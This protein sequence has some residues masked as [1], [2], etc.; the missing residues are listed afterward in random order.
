MRATVVG[1]GIGGLAA[2]IALARDGW[3]VE[4]LEKEPAFGELGAG[5]SLWANA[6]R[7]LDALGA[8]ERVRAQALPAS[9]AGIRDARGRW[10]SRTDVAELV[11]RFGATVTIRRS[12]L[13]ATLLDALP[14]GV[15]RP[16][17]EV[18]DV[19]ADGTVT[20]SA[21][22]STSDLVVGADG[23]HSVVRHALWPEAA[24]PRYVGYTAWR[25]LTT[26]TGEQLSGSESLGRGTRFGI[27]PLRGDGVYCFAAAPAPAGARSADGEPAELRRQFGGWHDPIPQLL[28][29]TPAGSV[30]RHDVYELP[31]LTTYRRGRVVLLGDAAHAMSPNLGQGACQA[32]EDAVTLAACGIDAY[33]RERRPRTQRITRRSR[34]IGAL[35]Q[36]SGAVPVALRN[37]VM[38]LVPGSALLDSLGPVVRWTPPRK[39]QP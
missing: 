18:T 35:A 24:P 21:G 25:F 31:P 26:W 37:A 9:S 34:Q 10:L 7:A 19:A 29:A 8:G 6:V 16:N 30:L 1:G 15:L 5:L 17:V 20:H 4:V 32:L 14:D 38:R 39:V 33:D 3:Q 22:R 12:D 2:A 27:V 36:W 13:L 11:R 28:A 23:I